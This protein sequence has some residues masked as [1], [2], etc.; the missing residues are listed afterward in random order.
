MKTK[1]V[2]LT[3]N[4]YGSYLGMEKGCFIIKDKHGKTEKYPLFE[5]EI[6][7]VQ[8][9]SG[10]SV[11]SGALASL[12]FWNIP[13]HV[14]TQKGRLVA[15]MKGLDDDAHIQTRIAQY[16]ALKSGKGLEIAKEI[17]TAKLQGQNQVLRKYGLRPLD[18]LTY[19]QEIKA[20]T[21]ELNL[22]RARLMKV[23][24]HASRR[25]FSQMF[26]LFNEGI[27]PEGRH[28]FKAYD[29]LNNIFNL[30]Y[31]IL[32]WKCH[33]ALVEAKLEP[34]LGFLHALQYGVSS[35]VCDLQ[36]VYRYL[37]EDFVITYCRSL[38]SKDFILKSELFSANKKGKRQYLN[39]A[40]TG[41]LTD[42]LNRYFESEIDVPR[43]R[44][45][46][47]QQLETLINEEALLLAAYLR[48]EKPI[49]KPRVLMLELRR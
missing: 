43:I 29:G 34:Y 5:N 10:N 39:D 30:A 36:D 4:G 25:Y 28:T 11:S 27:R 35:L 7:E 23:E 26:Q 32:G 9:K 47:K 3:L 14:F 15:T 2:K 6:S 48:G 20:I 33:Y 12:G 46:K 38:T 41:Q 8:I 22:V 42:Q 13:V 24:G 31:Q 21:G 1:T 40:K 49:W 44:R 37:I 16:E 45:G 17:V 19:Q 18:I